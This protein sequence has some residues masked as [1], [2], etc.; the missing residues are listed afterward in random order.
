MR[1][2]DSSPCIDAFQSRLN[3]F[4]EYRAHP[5]LDHLALV[6]ARV[7]VRVCVGAC[8][9]FVCACVFERAR[10][11]GWVGEGVFLTSERACV[12]CVCVCVCV[13]V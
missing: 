10:V 1:E 2:N 11:S 12:C 4:S 9:F 7:R 13:C 6:R 3:R 8:V 5:E